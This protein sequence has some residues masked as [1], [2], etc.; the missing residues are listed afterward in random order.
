M[1][2]DKILELATAAFEI[3][4]MILLITAKTTC[5]LVSTGKDEIIKQYAEY[6]QKATPQQLQA[7]KYFQDI[8]QKGMTTLKKAD[9]SAAK[10]KL[11]EAKKKIEDTA[12]SKT[13]K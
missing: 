1:S 8:S 2:K 7:L 10:K 3:T 13:K 12:S 5:K 4:K 11:E 9:V 6:K